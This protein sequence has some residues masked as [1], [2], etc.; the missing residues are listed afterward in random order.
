M[1]L[2]VYVPG[3]EASNKKSAPSGMRSGVSISIVISP[4]PVPFNDTNVKSMENVAPCR[5]VAGKTE[6]L[7]SLASP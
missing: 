6:N 1:I 7:V 5:P 2:S 4:V 3:F